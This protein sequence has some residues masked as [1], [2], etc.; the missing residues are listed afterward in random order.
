MS[1][2]NY[3]LEEK[4]SGR[5]FSSCYPLILDDSL[6]SINVR[7]VSLNECIQIV[8]TLTNCFEIK[9]MSIKGHRG[10]SGV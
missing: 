5:C 2:N 3:N 1:D 6:I 10:D 7:N 9:K 4:S 8:Y